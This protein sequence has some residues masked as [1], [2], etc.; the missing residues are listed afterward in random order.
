MFCKSNVSNVY[1]RFTKHVRCFSVPVCNDRPVCL[2]EQQHDKTNNGDVRQEKT[3][4][5]I[6]I[7]SV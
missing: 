2:Y 7:S 1:V 3:Q 5:V 6:G 4:I